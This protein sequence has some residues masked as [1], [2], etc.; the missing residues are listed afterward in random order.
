MNQK[1]KIKPPVAETVYAKL[2]LKAYNLTTCFLFLCVRNA[3][4][5]M[6][7][8]ILLCVMLNILIQ[9]FQFIWK[10]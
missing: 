2:I 5:K 6:Y 1:N 9:I 3:A 10:Q 7:Q 4:K 8:N